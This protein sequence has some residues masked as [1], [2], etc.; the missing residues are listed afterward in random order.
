MKRVDFLGVGV[1][2][3]GTSAL[4]SY[5]RMHPALCMAS[6]KEVHF[7]DEDGAFFR[8]A[9]HGY[10]GYHRHFAPT[11]ATALIGEIT[12]A[13]IYWNDAPRRIWQYNPAMK[14]IAVLR[15]PVTRAF[16]HWNMARDRGE[17]PLPFWDALQ[18]ERERC[19]ASLPLQN[20]P[21][22][23]VDRGFYTAQLRRL[24]AFFPSEQV[25]VLR[26]EDLRDRASETLDRIFD[27]LGVSRLPALPPTVAHAR[28]YV[29]RMSQREWRFLHDVF[30]FEIRALERLLRWDCSD[31]LR[32]PDDVDGES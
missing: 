1:Q 3:A 15:N 32:A 17:D 16:S 14:L 24:W 11:P 4:D 6:I 30:E 29:T 18:A 25:L 28:P 7:F 19:R 10:E 22:S 8:E 2:K 5:L 12:P 13:Y 27:F 20:R 31:W 23:Y 21:F 26:Y 9:M